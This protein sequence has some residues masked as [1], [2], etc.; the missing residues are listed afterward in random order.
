MAASYVSGA[1][2]Q[3]MLVCVITSI[4][5]PIITQWQYKRYY[6]EAALDK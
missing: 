4:L 3:V 1:T 6:G 2:S 5:T